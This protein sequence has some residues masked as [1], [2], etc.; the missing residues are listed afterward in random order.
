MPQAEGP[1]SSNGVL[2][3]SKPDCGVQNAVLKEKQFGYLSSLI[4]KA[5]LDATV[6]RGPLKSISLY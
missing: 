2:V 3:T 5:E 6:K 4:V 1:A